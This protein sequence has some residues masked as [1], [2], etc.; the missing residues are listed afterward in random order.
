MKSML[1]QPVPGEGAHY[2]GRL[3]AM[4]TNRFIEIFR[5]SDGSQ[6]LS[7]TN[8][9]SH[10]AIEKVPDVPA[11][12]VC[13]EGLRQFTGACRRCK[14]GNGG[15]FIL[16]SGFPQAWSMIVSKP[17][18]SSYS[19]V[20][21]YESEV[22]ETNCAALPEPFKGGL[23][24]CGQVGNAGVCR[25]FNS[26][27]FQGDVEVSRRKCLWQH[28]QQPEGLDKSWILD[29]GRERSISASLDSGRNVGD[30]EFASA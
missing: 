21:R 15:A 4:S 1:A 9:P 26:Q 19:R 12:Y 29:R 2:D 16:W 10:L 24:A 11:Q 7:N 3:P 25:Y 23:K 14:T 30:H 17:G 18:E 22:G 27:C 6:C 20:L 13:E 28:E 8:L 5:I